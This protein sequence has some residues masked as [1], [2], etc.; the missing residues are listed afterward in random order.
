[1]V[2]LKKDFIFLRNCGIMLSVI[3]IL[4]KNMDWTE[5]KIGVSLKDSDTAAAICNMAASGGI[6]IEDYSDLEQGAMEIAHIDLIDEDLIKKDREN[7]IIHMYISEEENP[8]ETLQY[9]SERLKAE[10]IGF[11]SDTGFVKS[12]DFENNWKKYFKIT[13]V[14][15]RLVICPSWEEY[16]NTENKAVLLIDPGAAFGTGTHATTSLCLELLDEF[17][18]GGQNVL[19]IG[20]GSGILGIASVLLGAE[21]ADG[22]DIDPVAVKV[23][24]ENAEQ[25]GVLDNVHFIRGN[26]ADEI[27]GKY[28]IICANIVAD[29]II[30]L[31]KNIENYMAEDSVFITSGIIDIRSD[32][33][34][35]AFCK[36]GLGIIKECRRDNWYAFA[37]KKLK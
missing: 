12:S 32:E 35:Q 19:D 28:N 23:A 31:C 11:T 24:K 33:V 34:R 16:E 3:I 8:A 18:T 15:K 27:S 13:E 21:S 10:K 37:L 17:V 26:L 36:A 30:G 4:E 14:G 9:I 22:V 5:I 20:C 25:N 1:M 29:V 7:V 6:Y 2:G